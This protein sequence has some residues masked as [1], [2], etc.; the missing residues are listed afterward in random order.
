GGQELL[1]EPIE[2]LDV[3][4]G[5]K[6]HGFSFLRAAILYS[7]TNL[8]DHERGHRIRARRDAA[9]RSGRFRLQARRSG[10]GRA[11]PVSDGADLVLLLVC[12]P[13]RIFL[14]SA[15]DQSRGAVGR[16]GRRA[17]RRRVLQL[18]PE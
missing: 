5:P 17:G 1:A 6:R 3:E 12:D 8:T 10:G 7:P 11:A 13:V 4:S 14:G 18:G 2:A 9:L 16:G 15:R